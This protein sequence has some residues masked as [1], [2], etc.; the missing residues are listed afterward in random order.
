MYSKNNTTS[1]HK[2][3]YFMRVAKGHS[4]QING[5]M[6]PEGAVYGK[7]NHWKNG[8]TYFVIDD[9]AQFAK[10]ATVA[11]K[12]LCKFQWMTMKKGESE[13][14]SR[15]FD[16]DVNYYSHD[17]NIMT[18]FSFF[19]DNGITVNSQTVKFESRADREIRE[20]RERER[21]AK[22]EARNMQELREM[23]EECTR[24]HGKNKLRHKNTRKNSGEIPLD[25]YER[26]I[27]HVR[28][29][30]KTSYKED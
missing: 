5:Y 13:F 17:F 3:K 19:E 20:I 21:A 8:D 1:M 10:L 6:I 11:D 16:I 4:T 7:F 24:K 9:F 22:E 15:L 28:S 30:F 29:N 18:L 25:A 26:V 27:C 23:M 2:N 12:R 14:H